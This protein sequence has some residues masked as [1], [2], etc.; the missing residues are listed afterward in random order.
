MICCSFVFQPGVYDDDFHRLDGEID[1]FARSLP[2]FVRADI[3]YSEDRSTIN[4]NY[5]FS[6]HD[7][8]RLLATY[9]THLEAKSQ[10]RRW[11]QRYKVVISEVT[12]TYGDEF[13]I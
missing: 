12:A 13:D 10:V 5:F 11:Y 8:V 9:P 7:A 4:A 1:T 6:D 2:G 3:W